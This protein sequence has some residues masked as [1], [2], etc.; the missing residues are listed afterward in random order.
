MFILEIYILKPF[1]DIFLF[2]KNKNG[3]ANA[4]RRYF[5]LNDDTIRRKCS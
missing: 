4:N 3:F 5:S 2:Y 1:L